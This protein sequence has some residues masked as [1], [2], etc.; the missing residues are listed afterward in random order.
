MDLAALTDEQIRVLARRRC[1]AVVEHL[2]TAGSLTVDELARRLIDED[3][4]VVETATYEDRLDRVRITLHHDWLP[5]LAE[6]GLVTYDHEAG[7]VSLAGRFDPGTEQSVPAALQS[8]AGETAGVIE[9]D[10]HERIV[11]CAYQLA[12]EADEELFCLID[13]RELVESNCVERARRAIDRGVDMAVGT[14]TERVRNLVAEELPEATV[15]EPQLDLLNTP[16]APRIGRLIL[17]DREHVLIGIRGA[18]DGETAMLGR[19][20]RNPLVVLVRG[21]LG[22]RLDHL[23]YQSEDFRSEL[24]G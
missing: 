3:V 7:T 21:L 11:Q 24:P 10:D 14:R 19:G 23:D 6:V 20:Q 16:Q 5:A 4:T 12:D 13:E 17:T 9:L 22:P 8:V 2:E 15:W 1:R 18:D